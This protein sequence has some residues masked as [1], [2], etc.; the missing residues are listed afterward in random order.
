MID[1]YLRKTV[2][3]LKLIIRV[4]SMLRE[5]SVTSLKKSVMRIIIRTTWLSR[6][7]CEGLERKS[8]LL[9]KRKQRRKLRPKV[10]HMKLLNPLFRMKTNKLMNPRFMRFKKRKT[11]CLQSLNK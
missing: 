3:M 9:M 1:Q 5:L 7:W 8:V 6:I 11:M 10:S 4:V 2:D